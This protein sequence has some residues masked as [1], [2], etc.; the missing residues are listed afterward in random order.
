VYYSTV[1]GLLDWL[2]IDGLQIDSLS[3]CVTKR[4]LMCTCSTVQGLL[5][6][7]EIDSLE[8]D[9]LS[10]CVTKRFLMCTTALYRPGFARLV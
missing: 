4:V 5:D 10:L 6:W 9:S 8:I 1:Q 2:E 3:L 7:F